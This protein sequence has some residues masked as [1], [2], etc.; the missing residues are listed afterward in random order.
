[1]ARW[2]EVTR[3]GTAVVP[4]QIVRR[5]YIK[6]TL[7]FFVFFLVFLLIANKVWNLVLEFPHCCYRV[8]LLSKIYTELRSSWL[9]QSD[10]DQDRA[11]LS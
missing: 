6:V 4:M 2:Q 3:L 10:A 8:L 1:M 9:H 7:C 5:M 11:S